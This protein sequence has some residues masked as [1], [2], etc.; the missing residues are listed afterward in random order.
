MVVASITPKTALVL[1]DQGKYKTRVALW[2]ARSWRSQHDIKPIPFE[3]R[4]YHD[5]C[6]TLAPLHS[7]I[8]SGLQDELEKLQ[9][10]QESDD[11]L[12][13]QGPLDELIFHWTQIA[14]KD[15]IKETN[16]KSCNAAYYLLKHI[17]QHWTN[18]L[19]L[20]NSTVAKG[21]YYSD[22]CHARVDYTLS[23]RE[24]MSEFI[25]ITRMTDNIAYIR[26]QM[27]HFC[28]AM[29][30]NLE[31][32]GVQLGRDEVDK[33]PFAGSTRGAEGFPFYQFEVASASG[34]S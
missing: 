3:S 5:G 22:D 25:S 11:P 33:E 30:L 18:Q 12:D 14:P 15:L 19:E 9:T 1:R 27:N 29:A 21:E 4:A 8:S 32:L 13:E 16:E 34:A 26:R 20:I 2:N 17:A 24:W 10:K 7:H 28:R 23:G 6:P 31:R